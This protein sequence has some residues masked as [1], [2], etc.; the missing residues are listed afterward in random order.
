M[1]SMCI[2]IV[3]IH[4]AHH[5]P[6]SNLHQTCENLTIAQVGMCLY[7]TYTCLAPTLNLLT[8]HIQNTVYTAK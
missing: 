3:H 5:I 7:S 1:K 2:Y 4:I 8:T 6:N